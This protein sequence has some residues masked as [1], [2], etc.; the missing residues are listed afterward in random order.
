MQQTKGSALGNIW[1]CDFIYKVQEYFLNNLP[2]SRK[3]FMY[4]HLPPPRKK[5]KP[6][7][8]PAAERLFKNNAN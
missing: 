1:C 3:A 4:T 6:K 2:G 7:P 5:K 8:K